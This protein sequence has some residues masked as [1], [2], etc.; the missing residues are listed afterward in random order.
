MSLKVASSTATRW[1]GLV[2]RGVDPTADFKKSKAASGLQ[3]MTLENLIAEAKFE[4][5]MSRAI[6]R[7]NNRPGR[8]VAEAEASI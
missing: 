8:V 1:H 7:E 2:K 5:A 3:T 4:F 6:W